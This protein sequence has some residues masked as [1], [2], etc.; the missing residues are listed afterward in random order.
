M[1]KDV[2]LLSLPILPQR[3]AKTFDQFHA[4]RN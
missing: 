1:H 3:Q 4:Q 2:S